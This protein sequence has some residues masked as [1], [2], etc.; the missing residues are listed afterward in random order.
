LRQNIL[1]NKECDERDKQRESEIKEKRKAKKNYSQ[2]FKNNSLD[3]AEADRKVQAN[4]K[5][6]ARKSENKCKEEFESKTISK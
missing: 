4:E 3:Q 5:S 2:K 6:K 1:K